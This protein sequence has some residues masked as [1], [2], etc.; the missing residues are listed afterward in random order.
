MQNDA[1]EFVDLY[2]PRKCSSSSRIISAK[3]H[4][5]IQLEIV[6]VDQA[7]GRLIPGK[8]TKYAICGK[9]RY[10]GESDD[11]ILRLAQRDGII[12]QNI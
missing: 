7:T 3:D 10:M 12:P 5:S 4:A 6:E 1:G 8:T 11:S 9:Q 2:V